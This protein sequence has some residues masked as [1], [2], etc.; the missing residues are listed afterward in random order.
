[1]ICIFT[2]HMID[3]PQR[4]TPR[5]P[6]W[7]APAVSNIITER[8]KSLNPKYGYAP[9][10]CGGDI[11]FLETLESLQIPMRIMLPFPR[12]DF[13]KTSVAFAGQEW[14][15]RYHRLLDNHI[16]E[17]I[18]TEPFLGEDVLYSHGFEV[19]LGT[20]YKHA[21]RL[22]CEITVIALLDRSSSR[23]PGGTL[24]ILKYWGRRGV[25]I[26]F[27]NLTML[28][29]SM[30][31]PEIND[32]PIDVSNHTLSHQFKNKELSNRCIRTMLF[33]DVVG[34]SQ[35]NEKQAPVFFIHFLAFATQI[36]KNFRDNLVFQNTWG[37][38]LFLVF[39]SVADAAEFALE[40]RDRFNNEN[41]SHLELPESL[42]IRIAL[43]AGPVFQAEDP[44]IQK[45]NF[46]GSHVNKAARMEPIVEPGHIY[47]SEAM[48]A[49]LTAQSIHSISSKYVGR[50]ELAKQYGQAEVY[51][52]NWN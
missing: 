10:A 35:L 18:T 6:N 52:L 41:W 23:L 32:D 40:L 15:D 43:H 33:A 5:Y 46:F 47:C 13:L 44:I 2:G 37:D 36:L 12:E 21:E 3:H 26:D 45:P 22:N 20:A 50:Y 25:K 11:Q 38:C 27:I 49:L 9:A 24:D 28:R 19:M 14:I 16:Y 7:L 4:E 30:P 29:N 51:E 17:E 31:V 1:M 34:F 42:S 39:S 8:V 48:A